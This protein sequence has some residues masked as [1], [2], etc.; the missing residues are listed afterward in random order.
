MGQGTL[1]LVDDSE[2][3]PNLHWFPENSAVWADCLEKGVFPPSVPDTTKYLRAYAG[4]GYWAAQTFDYEWSAIPAGKQVTTMDV[5]IYAAAQIYT[6]GIPGPPSPNQKITVSLYAAG[7]SVVTFDNFAQTPSWHSG[8][9][10]INQP[11]GNLNT[12]PVI[13]SAVNDGTD[14]QNWDLYAVVINLN[15]ADD[16]RLTAL[17][18]PTGLTQVFANT[19]AALK[20]WRGR[21]DLAPSA[22]TSYTIDSNAADVPCGTV[23]LSGRLL[24]YFDRSG[25]A[26]CV[27][28]ALDGTSWLGDDM[29]AVTVFATYTLLHVTQSGMPQYAVLYKAGALYLSRNIASNRLSWS[30][31]VQIVGSLASEPVAWIMPCEDGKLR[32][33][34]QVASSTPQVLTCGRQDGIGWN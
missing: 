28:S 19:G 21:H 31:P 20:N 17:L 4:Q 5:S 13:I 26:C 22:M 12:S 30:T 9:S 3:A 23:S 7:T 6:D 32:C 34:W 10:S 8:T 24:H 15:W 25:V 29:A 16:V 2:L 27:E 33:Y 11:I 18:Q 14:W 1:H